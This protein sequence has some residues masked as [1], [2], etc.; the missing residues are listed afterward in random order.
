MDNPFEDIFKILNDPNLEINAK[1][2]SLIENNYIGIIQTIPIDKLSPDL[3]LTLYDM[4]NDK[5]NSY[6]TQ[7]IYDYFETWFKLN[8]YNEITLEYFIN[9]LKTTVTS[10]IKITN[11]Y[12]WPKIRNS[13]VLYLWLLESYPELYQYRQR[14][15]LILLLIR[16]DHGDILKSLNF[17]PKMINKYY[18]YVFEY[19]SVELKNWFIQKYQLKVPAKERQNKYEIIDQAYQRKDLA[20]VNRLFKESMDVYFVDNLTANN[21]LEVASYILLKKN[22]YILDDQ[23]MA[24]IFR[25]Q[26]HTIQKLLKFKFLDQKSIAKYIKYIF[27]YDAYNII[28]YLIE[29]ELLPLNSSDIAATNGYFDLMLELVNNGYELKIKDDNLVKLAFENN[30]FGALEYLI[31]HRYKYDIQTFKFIDGNDISLSLVKWYYEQRKD[32]LSGL[33]DISTKN[34]NIDVFKWLLENDINIP[35]NDNIIPNIIMNNSTMLHDLYRNYYKFELTAE[36]I[37]NIYNNDALELALDIDNFEPDKSYDK[38][39][40]R[41]ARYFNRGDDDVPVFT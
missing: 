32:G 27:K 9:Y 15:P 23:I 34:N 14:N 28:S 17:K 18:E 41:V 13:N 33:Y 22:L 2:E 11:N 30:N 36:D 6:L 7:I 35:D 26:K 10:F 29:E 19:G 38:D 20:L 4:K 8:I 16:Y 25:D 3:V 21:M 39:K 31:E 5:I 1:L 12:T 37:K 40:S 24:A